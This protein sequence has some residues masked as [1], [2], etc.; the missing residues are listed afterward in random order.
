MITHLKIKA[1][2]AL[3]FSVTSGMKA[4]MLAVLPFLF[5][6]ALMNVCYAGSRLKGILFS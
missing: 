5:D 1:L 2:Y 6:W 3:C 4:D